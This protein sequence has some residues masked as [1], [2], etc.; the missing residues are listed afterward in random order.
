M[1]EVSGQALMVLIQVLD[2]KIWALKARVDAASPD[3]DDLADTEDELATC[4][5]VA[6]E[7]R[8]AYESAAKTTGDLPPY[9]SLVRFG[10]M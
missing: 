5:A 10:V 3:A 1:A 2:E 8:D 7:L 6:D 9:G 4:T